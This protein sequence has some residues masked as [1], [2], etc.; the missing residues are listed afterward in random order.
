M[1]NRFLLCGL[2][3][4]TAIVAKAQFESVQ[5][6]YEKNWFGEN[7]KLPAETP[8][9]LS[10]VLPQNISSVA[11]EIYSS[12]NREKDP[13]HTSVWTSPVGTDSATNFFI[14][15]SYSLRSSTKYTIEIKYYRD[16]T[17]VEKTNLKQQVYD[18]VR[19][20]VQLNVVA[21]K[22]DV[23]LNKDPKEM[24]K[25]LNK[26]MRDGLVLFKS[27]LNV[28]F[29][30]FSDLVLDQL[31][32]MDDLN[33]KK[34]KFNVLKKNEDEETNNQKIEYFKV[35]L[36]NLQKVIK[37]EIDQYLSYDLA[38]LEIS[39]VITD[40]ET[41]HTRNVVAINVGYGA[42]HNSGGFNEKIDYDSAPYLGISFPLANPNFSGKFWSNSSISTGVFFNDFQFDN[43]ETYTGPLVGRPFY[44]AYGY[45][46]AYF[47]RFNLGA[48]LLENKGGDNTLFVRPFIGASIEIN[49]WLGLNR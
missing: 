49:L 13:L 4:L 41:Q 30:G 45:K 14:P 32:N 31:E 17:P 11:V 16:M 33:L 47:I 48:T 43:G 20:Y 3:L 40:Y 15:V 29:P 27:K 28:S 25:D 18:A 2:L 38:I 5:Y 9:I 42:V 39:R 26:L 34:G 1:V 8:W 21:S 24:V 35:Q 22:N 7:Q 36:E 46:A 10:G 37:R 44:L 12:D 23:D 6:D 19:S